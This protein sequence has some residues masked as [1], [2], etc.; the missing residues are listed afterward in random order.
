MYIHTVEIYNFETAIFNTNAI[1]MDVISF[2]QSVLGKVIRTGRKLTC[3][4]FYSVCVAS[5]FE[6]SRSNSYMTESQQIT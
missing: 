6:D 4:S 3:C 5:L 2:Q 1:E